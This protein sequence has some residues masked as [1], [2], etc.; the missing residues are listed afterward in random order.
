M[1]PR[2][3][4][5]RGALRRDRGQRRAG[6][7]GQAARG[8][9]G[10]GLPPRRGPPADRGRARA[11]ARPRWPRRSPRS[12]D[13]TFRRIQ[14]TPDLLPTDVTGVTVYNQERGD[15][16]FQPGRGVR[17]HRARR[18]DQPRQRRRPS[19]RCSRHGGAP[20]HRR[21]RDATRS[22]RP[23]MVIATQNPIEHEGTYPLPEAQLDR[24]MMRMSHRLPGR[25]RPRLEILGHARRRVD[26]RRHRAGHRR[27]AASPR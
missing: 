10:P 24:F 18:R 26:A 19:R 6:R 25:A 15:F 2:L 7:P 3:G 1:Q 11:S 21:R 9:A 4:A 14:F 12:I 8:R 23:F 17:Q 20:G 22:A 16:E 27:A 13:C 5:V